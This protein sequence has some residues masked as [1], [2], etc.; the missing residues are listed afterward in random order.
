MAEAQKKAGIEVS[1]KPK[2]VPTQ[3]EQEQAYQDYLKELG[4]TLVGKCY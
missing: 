1:I 3:A 2:K 4:I